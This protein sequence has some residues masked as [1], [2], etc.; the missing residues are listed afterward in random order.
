MTTTADAEIIREWEAN[1]REGHRN[2]W[3]DASDGQRL[4]TA[5]TSPLKGY[6]MGYRRGQIAYHEWAKESN[7]Q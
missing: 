3:V 7:N 6:S 1:Y 2:G 4:D 5:L